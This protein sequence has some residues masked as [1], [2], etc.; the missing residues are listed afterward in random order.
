MP[1]NTL[2]SWAAFPLESPLKTAHDEKVHQEALDNQAKNVFEEHKVGDRPN[3]VSES[4]VPNTGL[5][6][7]FGPRRAPFSLLFVCQSELTEFG[8]ELKKVLPSP[9]VETPGEQTF[10]GGVSLEFA[11][12]VR[13]P[14]VATLLAC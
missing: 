5:S 13:D 3:M 2:P 10:Y 11:W 1:P 7:I 9:K 12:E 14:W 6:E 8:A 4:T